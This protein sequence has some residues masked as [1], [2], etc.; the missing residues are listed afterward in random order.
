ML[1]IFEADMM[2]S[3]ALSEGS[4]SKE[5]LVG[6]LDEEATL[7]LLANR[8]QRGAGRQQVISEVSTD[9]LDLQTATK[10]IHTT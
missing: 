1:K 10:N 9:T 6:D 5:D 7:D 4:K 8:G 2:T 3:S